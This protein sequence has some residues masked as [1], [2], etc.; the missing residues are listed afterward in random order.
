MDSKLASRPFTWTPFSTELLLLSLTQPTIHTSTVCLACLP[1]CQPGSLGQQPAE[2]RRWP[3][4]VGASEL[5]RKGEREREEA[6]LLA[7]SWRQ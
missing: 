3:N 6:V 1:A 4:L 7:S 2:Q 5:K